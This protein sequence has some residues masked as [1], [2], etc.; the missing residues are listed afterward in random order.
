MARFLVFNINING[1]IRTFHLCIQDIQLLSCRIDDDASK[2][3]LFF[4]FQSNAE[5]ARYI[6]PCDSEQEAMD[7][8]ENI[9]SQLNKE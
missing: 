3:I 9:T 1:K 4:S 8:I 5:D 6:I 7:F 2:V